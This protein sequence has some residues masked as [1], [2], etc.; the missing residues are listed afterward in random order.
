M[1]LIN[2]EEVGRKFG[3]ARATVWRHAKEIPGYPQPI[4]VHGA[5]STRWVESECDDYL[6]MMMERARGIARVS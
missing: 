3:C 1:K 6:R 2:D 5:R 4:R